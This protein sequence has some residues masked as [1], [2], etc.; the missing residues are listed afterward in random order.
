VLGIRRSAVAAAR[1]FRGGGSADGSSQNSASEEAGYSTKDIFANIANRM[2]VFLSDL[3]VERHQTIIS[4]AIPRHQ[5][6]TL[7]EAIAACERSTAGKSFYLSLY[8]PL[9]STPA[10]FLCV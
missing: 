7:S 1:L 6:V 8:T 4:S 9:I 10:V 5:I 2:A 3:A